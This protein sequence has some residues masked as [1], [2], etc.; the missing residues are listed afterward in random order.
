[1]L[2]ALFSCS[3]SS[4]TELVGVWQGV[5]NEGMSF[6]WTFEEDGSLIIE[7]GD[8]LM[9]SESIGGK[10][11]WEFSDAERDPTGEYSTLTIIVDG[12]YLQKNK[13]RWIKA[14]SEKK[15]EMGLGDINTKDERSFAILTK[16]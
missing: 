9:D 13:Y 10:L 5:G 8:E 16:Q 6:T 14:V 12:A 3:T 2:L 1:M 4:D 15:L 11:S 7:E